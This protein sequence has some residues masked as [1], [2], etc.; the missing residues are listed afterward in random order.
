[1]LAW[2]SPVAQNLPATREAWV[3]SLGWEDALEEGMATHWSILVENS[4]DRG[5]EGWQ[6]AAHG[7]AKGQT[8]LS[9]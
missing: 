3:R 1:M 2:A 4:M 6:A 8:C 5:M 7:V 9:N